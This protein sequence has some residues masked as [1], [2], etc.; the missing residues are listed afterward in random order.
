[1][2]HSMYHLYV[3]EH[4]SLTAREIADRLAPD[5]S[6]AQR[7]LAMRRVQHWTAEE[8]LD[9]NDYRHTGRGT[10]RRYPRRALLDGAVLWEMSERNMSVQQMRFARMSIT[11]QEEPGTSPGPYRVALQGERRVLLLLDLSDSLGAP[12]LIDPP[13]STIPLDWSVGLWIDLTA[14]FVRLRPYFAD[15][16]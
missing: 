9:P 5:E 12:V 2:N 11:L 10:V 15:W 1:M 6:P 13:S 4:L 7:S 16:L 8:L 14:A 3:M